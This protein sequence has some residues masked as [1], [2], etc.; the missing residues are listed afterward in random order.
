MVLLL[1]IL[2]PLITGAFSFAVKGDA[3]K[4]L[5]LISTT[6][7]LALSAYVSGANFGAPVSYDHEWI[8]MM[9]T[10]FSLLADGM[11]SMLVLLTGIVMMVVMIAQINK[12]VEH[13]GAFYGLLL[14]SQAGLMGVFL[15]SD[16]L[17]FYVFWELALIPV[18]FLC[19]QWGG[20]KRIPVT[21]KFFIY[22]FVGSLM[23]LSGLIYLSLQGG[24]YAWADITKAGAALPAA[25]QHWLFWLMFI[26]FAIKMPVFPFHTWQPD[27][28][29]QSPTPVTIVLSALMVKMGLFA[30]LRWLMPTV[31]VGV[32][33][34]SDT[35]VVL[36][37][38][39]IVYASCI[40]IV[41]TDIKRMIAYSSIAHMGLMCATAF[42]HNGV[43]MHG[44]MVQMFNHGINI[45][46]M[47]LIVS[48]VEQ[49]WG[50]RD[51]TKLGGMASSA[52][53]MAIALVIISLANIALPLTN[54][55]IGEFMMFNGL[56]S[57]YIS[58]HTV[59][60]VLAG[61]GIILGA[62]YTLNMIQ[63]VA[64]GEKTTMVVA[65][66]LAINEYISLAVI[67]TVIIFLGVYPKPLLD[68][69]SGVAQM[70]VK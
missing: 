54:G 49:R 66:D 2:I 34:W 44:V 52:P 51:M 33:Y 27:A 59:M 64:Y 16:A 26:A 22:T 37:V 57:G 19:S 42:A 15:A 7:T 11:S 68:L 61:L 5:A 53:Q 62:V 32:E 25:S 55:F 9:G 40:A 17:L 1:L 30:V 63:K 13:P 28:Y 4:A 60:T 8:P 48:M 70:I 24:S 58:N 46:G 6:A 23:M 18:Y 43:G 10:R 50:T 67:I 45:T 38:I 47:W 39:G 31:P 21:F 35:V 20:E 65:K 14:L 69:T 3:A 36:S 41:Q 56:F 12:D 29:E